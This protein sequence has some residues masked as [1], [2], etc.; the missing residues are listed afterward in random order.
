VSDP[1]LA[2][3]ARTKKERYDGHRK[4]TVNLP[5]VSKNS[6]KSEWTPIR[7]IGAPSRFMQITRLLIFVMTQIF[8]I[9]ESY[10][11]REGPNKPVH[12]QELHTV[13]D[14]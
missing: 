13:M 7:I 11:H 9:N 2:D 14:F 5:I 6:Q 8:S 12:I 1:A 3:G 4:I 10:S